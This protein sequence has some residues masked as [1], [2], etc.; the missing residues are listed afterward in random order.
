MPELTGA[1]LCGRLRYT[2]T[3]EPVMSAV[4]HCRDCQRFTIAEEP[5]T[6]PGLGILNV[7]TL[8]DPKSVMRAR[9]VFCGDALRWVQVGG[10]MER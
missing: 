2:I 10:D 3:A 7:G 9:E 6:R 5:G 4:C 8:D 1:C